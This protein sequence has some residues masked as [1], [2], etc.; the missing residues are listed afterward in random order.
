M[1]KACNKKERKTTEHRFRPP[2]GCA[3]QRIRYYDRLLCNAA[4]NH[5]TALA[6]SCLI[7]IGTKYNIMY[8][9]DQRCASMMMQAE[10]GDTMVTPPPSSKAL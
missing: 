5:E 10:F 9:A 3:S 1:K 8:P 2:Q 7:Q 4:P 6:L